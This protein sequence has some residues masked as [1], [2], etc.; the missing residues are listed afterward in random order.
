MRAYT[1]TENGFTFK[2][3]NKTQARREHWE[4]WSNTHIAIWRAEKWQNTYS[5][6]RQQ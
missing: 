1:F 3:I 4:R 6:Q 5:E 2:R